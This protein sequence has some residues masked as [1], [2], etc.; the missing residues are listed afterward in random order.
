MPGG[1]P[2][3]PKRTLY[4]RSPAG[5]WGPYCD[6]FIP[7][8]IAVTLRTTLKPIRKP[9]ELRMGS[10]SLAVLKLCW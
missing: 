2:S 7:E 6:T 5:I 4:Q 8:S 10:V 9:L 1:S 3:K